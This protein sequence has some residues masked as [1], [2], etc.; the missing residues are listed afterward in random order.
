[1]KTQWG[2][3]NSQPCAPDPLPSYGL[4][5]M[6]SNFTRRRR[7]LHSQDE[8]F[9]FT[10]TY[11]VY[12]TFLCFSFTAKVV[13]DLIFAFLVWTIKKLVATFVPPTFFT[14]SSKSF[15]NPRSSSFSMVPLPS[16]KTERVMMQNWPT[17]GAARG[18]GSSIKITTKSRFLDPLNFNYHVWVHP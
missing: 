7:C 2:Y 13:C 15:R 8:V 16:C 5:Q 9:T 10:R 12:Q 18:K 6:Q 11:Y 17:L 14:N 4:F 1:M 3:P